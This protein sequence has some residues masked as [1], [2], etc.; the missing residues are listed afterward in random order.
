MNGRDVA[1]DRVNELNSVT[2]NTTQ[3]KLGDY[4]H[5]AQGSEEKALN[6]DVNVLHARLEQVD[7]PS[8]TLALGPARVLVPAST[9]QGAAPG[10][11]VDLFVRPEQLRVAGD[12][13]P[14][15]VQAAA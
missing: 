6:G 10:A 15:A 7:G 12:G 8:A 4:I 13:T 1:K 9:L 14:V 2:T 11:M 5:V 3:F